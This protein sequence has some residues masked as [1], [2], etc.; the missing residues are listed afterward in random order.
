MCD[1]IDSRKVKARK[2]YRCDWCGEPI[3]RGE[4]YARDTIVNDGEIYTW[5]SHDE[6]QEL[7]SLFMNYYGEYEMNSS[8]FEAGLWD[9]HLDWYGDREKAQEAY[10]S[11]TVAERVH[12]CI[13]YTKDCIKNKEEK[14]RKLLGLK[15][16]LEKEKR[17]DERS[18]GQ[19]VRR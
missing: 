12:N 14:H 10:H 3:H 11:H 4:T 19:L 16:K 17:Y 2:E 13:G 9:V 8:D 5:H 15:D 18:L 7:A 1:V 6:C